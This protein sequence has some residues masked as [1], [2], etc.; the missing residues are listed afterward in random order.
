VNGPQTPTTRIVLADDHPVYRRG[1]VRAIFSRP[2]LKV[3]EEVGDGTA[4]LEAITRLQPGAA[5]LDIGMPGLDGLGVVRALRARGDST[6]VLLLSGSADA[7]GLY[8]AFAAGASGYL[9]KTAEPDEICDAIA[10]VARGETLFAPE[11]TAALAKEIRTR[12]QAAA[13]PLLSPR[14]Q[15]VLRL[16]AGGR[17]AAQI[18][19]DLYLSVPTVR[20]HLQ[21]AYHKLEVSDRAAAVA[22]AMRLGLID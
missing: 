15:E 16:T 5:L 6:P 14:E 7:E 18:A 17:S 10:A 12:E 19:A 13:R 4:A 9:L 11:L 1:L 2:D 22:V 21:N 8:A 3:I 20:T